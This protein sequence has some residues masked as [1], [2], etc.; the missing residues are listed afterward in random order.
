MQSPDFN[1]SWAD[2]TEPDNYNYKPY[3]LSDSYEQ[4]SAE[5]PWYPGKFLSQ[6]AGNVSSGIGSGISDAVE[7]FQKMLI[8]GILLFFG[9]TV[10][11]IILV[12]AGLI[13]FSQLKK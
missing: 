6:S 4:Y 7:S 9:L 2:R 3:V 12:F 1:Y 11:L 13:T 8:I 10:G 5:L